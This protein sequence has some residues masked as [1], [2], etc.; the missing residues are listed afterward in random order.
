MRKTD[1]VPVLLLVL[2]LLTGCSRQ[3][4][5]EEMLRPF[6]C[7]YL[8]S[9]EQYSQTEGVLGTERVDLGSGEED[10]EAIAAYYLAG[11][12]SE[13]LHSP[14]P[15]GLR[16]LGAERSGSVL[17]L[18]LSE[19][20]SQL[21]GVDVTLAAACF[22]RTFTQLEGV[23]RVNLSCE[24]SSFSGLLAVSYSPEDFLFLDTAQ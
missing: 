4:A 6:D 2:G 12:R 1:W 15:K 21:S 13:T 7:F 9:A 19:E 20:F 14:F 22:V 24:G 5:Q 17:Y 16:C 23:E 18:K 3:P 11:P 8:Q 10:Y